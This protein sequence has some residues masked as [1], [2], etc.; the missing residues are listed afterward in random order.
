MKARWAERPTS[1]SFAERG[2]QLWGASARTLTSTS[3]R[4]KTHGTQT[5]TLPS[6]PW[7]TE[8][9]HAKRKLPTL[10]CGQ[11]GFAD[12]VY[13]PLL[14]APLLPP[15]SLYFS[16][17]AFTRRVVFLWESCSARR[18]VWLFAWSAEEEEEEAAAKSRVKSGGRWSATPLGEEA[19]CAS[20][21][22]VSASRPRRAQLGFTPTTGQSG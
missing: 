4:A 16:V 18:E 13:F 5:N 14:G 20:W 3:L 8:R 19:C 6:A 10:P 11:Q 7:K 12:K 9:G 1:E 17:T 21:R 15:L 22:S 2:N